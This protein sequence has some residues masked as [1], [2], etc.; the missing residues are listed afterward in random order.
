MKEISIL[1]VGIGGYGENYVQILLNNTDGIKFAGAVDPFPERC[2]RFSEIKEKGIPVYSTL[3]EF[4]EKH[5]ADMAVISTPIHLHV[6]QTIFC[7]S[8]GSNVLCEKPLCAVYQDSVKMLE[9]E[10]EYG[11]FVAIAYQ[12]SFSDSIQELKKDIMSGAFGKAVRLKSF[13][14]FP[15]HEN[16]YKR[17]SWAGKF[18][19]ANGS[20]VLDSPIMNSCAHQLH[21]MF[22]VLGSER[23]TSVWPAS[24]QAEL[25]RA[26][27][28]VENFDTAALRCKTYDNVE[29]L[30]YSTQA[31]DG[32]KGVKV[33]PFWEFEFEK[34]VLYHVDSYDED[35][36]VRLEDGTV[37]DYS[38]QRGES[39]KKFWE[40][41]KCIRTG[42]RPA[43]GIEAAT[44]H[45]LCVNGMQESM[46][47]V[48]LPESMLETKI[49]NGEKWTYI[50]GIK[51]ILL[52]C[53]HEG[54]LPSEMGYSFAKEGK[55]VD[56]RGYKEFSGTGR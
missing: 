6:E 34:A 29:I 55:I 37:K 26:N 43:C 49:V 45:V 30:M 31:M 7:L 54:K 27:Q 21:N 46:E 56:L 35:F 13:L 39:F 32:G 33:G 3:D 50:K 8:K 42:S 20:W 28:L 4:Y 19:T 40:A 12:L 51:D 44:P 18:K 2:S 10:K 17:N 25:Y 24:V 22:Y 47:V 15:R 52:N 23:E 36:K 9:A 38:V 41:I 1:L 53:Y 16:Y 14:I 5:S 11:R 48:D